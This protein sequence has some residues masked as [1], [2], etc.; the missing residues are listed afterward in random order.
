M[1]GV[2]VHTL[3]GSEDQSF[4]RRAVLS[5]VQSDLVQQGPGEPEERMAPTGH[6]R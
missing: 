6:G 5:A 2:L 3:V 1:L 4:T